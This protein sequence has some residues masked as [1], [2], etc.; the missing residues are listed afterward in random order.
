MDI[1]FYHI[2]YVLSKIYVGIRAKEDGRTVS[3]VTCWFAQ[4]MYVF[5]R[6]C[7]HL[8][9]RRSILRPIV[10]KYIHCVDLSPVSYL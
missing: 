8:T 10:P 2:L 9:K 5:K 6:S 1:I 4:V 7:R 3:V